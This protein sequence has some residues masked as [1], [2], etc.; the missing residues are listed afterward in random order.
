MYVAPTT[1]HTCFGSDQPGTL[2]LMRYMLDRYSYI[3][4]MGTYVCRDVA[5]TNTISQHACGRAGDLGIPTLS[6]GAPNLSLGNPVVQLLDQ[7]AGELGIAELIYNRVIY[8]DGSPDGRLYGGVHPHYD[9]V[10]YTL[11]QSS[12]SGLTYPFIVSVAGPTGA[13]TEEEVLQRGDSGQMVAEL[14]KALAD[15]FGFNNG[16]FTPLAANSIFDGQAFG[17]GEDGGFGATCE[18]NV[19]ALQARMGVPQTGIADSMVQAVV[20]AKYGGVAGLTKAEADTLYSPKGA[21]TKATADTL[22]AA[23][24]TALTKTEAATTYLSKTE[25]AATYSPITTT[26]T[27]AE[28]ATI[29]ATKAAA[30]SKAVADDLYA[31]KSHVHPENA[32]AVHSHPEYAPVNHLHS[33]YAPISTTLTKTEAATVYATKAEAL[34]KAAAD[35][36]YAAKIHQHTA[37][38]TTTEE[39]TVE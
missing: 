17:P 5:G 25:A 34:T 15:F 39:I 32:P 1:C 14:Q 26:L 29:Y 28:A 36:L 22:Y 8:D 9:H 16:A 33:Q 4:D 31:A 23:K 38:R 12:A 3:R 21:L 24:T 10:H 37:T 30:L 19:K 11:N 20:F 7:F 2:A 6:G 18:A 35:G 27:K 13:L